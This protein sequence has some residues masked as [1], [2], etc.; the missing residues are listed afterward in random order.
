M[1]FT[2]A[3]IDRAIYEYIRLKIV[4]AGY[5]PD[6]TQYQ[7]QESWDTARTLLSSTKPHG[8]IDIFGVGSADDRDELTANKIVIN[9]TNEDNST[10]SGGGVEYEVANNTSY[11]VVDLPLNATNITYEIKLNTTVVSYERIMSNIITKALGMTPA[12]KSINDDGSFSSKDFYIKRQQKIDSSSLY[13]LQKIFIFK[14]LD[15]FLS[16][17]EELNTNTVSSINS[18]TFTIAAQNTEGV[19]FEVTTQ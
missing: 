16:S 13:F 2:L 15:V 18:I 11:K 8:L 12:L 14:V 4:E 19:E 7:T 10:L 5:L 17:E 9:R 3:E 6:M 1:T